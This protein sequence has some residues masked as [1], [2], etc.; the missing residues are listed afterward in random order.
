MSAKT[1]LQP[2]LRRGLRL[3]LPWL[4]ATGLG[5]PM[6]HARTEAAAAPAAA[7]AEPAVKA[8]LTQM[9]VVTENGKETLKPVQSVK[10]GDLIEYRVVY[11][12]RSPKAV[13]DVQ[14]ELPIPEGLEYQPKSA[15]PAQNAEAAVKGG[16]FA[17]EPLMR[18]A[19]GGKKEPVPYSEYRRLRWTLGQIAAGAKTEV[20]ARAR[21]SAGVPANNQSASQPAAQTAAGR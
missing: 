15:R 10:P 19:A 9:Q 12:N 5:L 11:T 4:L 8:E 16:A 6:A 1:N 18:E 14:A 2:A 7:Q 17:R 20:S 3:I 21:V 13:R